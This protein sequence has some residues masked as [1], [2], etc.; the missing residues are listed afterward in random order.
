MRGVAGYVRALAWSI[1]LPAVTTVVA[2]ANI[3]RYIFEPNY[4]LANMVLGMVG[5]GPYQFL[6]SPEQALA[7]VIAVATRAGIGT[8]ILIISAVF[9]KGGV[10][11]Y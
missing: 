9:R 11:S 6:N 5:L 4:G 10:Q 3:W 7:S 2:V 8:S 1:P